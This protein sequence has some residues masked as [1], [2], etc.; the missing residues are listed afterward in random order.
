MQQQQQGNLF[1]DTT[2]L[3]L[4]IWWVEYYTDGPIKSVHFVLNM[5]LG[6]GPWSW[7]LMHW[8]NLY[9]TIW[10]VRASW[11]ICSLCVCVLATQSCP[12][13]WDPMD[14]NPPGFSVH[15]ILQACILEW[16]AMP[17]S[18]GASQPR[19]QTQISCIAGRLFSIWTTRLFPRAAQL[20]F[21]FVW[22]EKL[23]WPQL[24]SRW[25]SALESSHY[26][27]RKM[28]RKIWVKSQHWELHS[29]KMG[30]NSP[31]LKLEGEGLGAYMYF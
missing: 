31:L 3:F 27:L 6:W 17:S 29:K 30:V 19:D 16:I 13:L 15:G 8:N 21:T 7:G 25:H 12:T 2:L 18:R 1:I 24:S 28:Q 10:H 5:R 22:R 14:C 26:A 23:T 4:K 20:K 11:T 9:Y